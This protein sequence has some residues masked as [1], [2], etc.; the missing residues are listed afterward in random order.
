[1]V[2][3]LNIFTELNRAIVPEGMA[4]YLGKKKKN[5]TQSIFHVILSKKTHN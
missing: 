1:M 5:N 2:I 4:H 3:G